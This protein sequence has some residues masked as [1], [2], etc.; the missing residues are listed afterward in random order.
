MFLN[1]S[2]TEKLSQN[3]SNLFKEQESSQNPYD[4]EIICKTNETNTIFKCHKTILYAR[5]YVFENFLNENPNEKRIILEDVSKE[6]IET[7]L[8]YL[9]T[10]KMQINLENLV[11]LSVFSSNYG[12]PDLT[13]I[14]TS[15]LQ[16]NC[17]IENVVELL[18]L[19]ELSQL[20]NFA[21]I[22]YEFLSVNFLTFIESPFVQELNENQWERILS[23][24]KLIADEFQIFQSLIKWAK[25]KSNILNPTEKLTEKEKEK[26][27]DTLINIVSEIR[28][29][30]F[31]QNQLDYV[32]QAS[33]VPY[34]LEKTLSDFRSWSSFII[35]DRYFD[36]ID[37]YEKQFIQQNQKNSIFRSRIN[38]VLFDSLI[39]EKHSHMRLIKSWISDHKFFH[40]M[41]LGFSTRKDG[42]SCQKW[43]DLCDNQ[44]K[45]LILI[46]TSDNFIFGGFTSVGWIQMHLFFLLQNPRNDPP[47][48]F[49]VREKSYALEYDYS[50]SGPDFVDFGLSQDMHQGH[51]ESFGASYVIPKEIDFDMEKS[52]DYL[53]GSFGEWEVQELETYFI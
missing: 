12:F 34:S 33:L 43:H 49:L 36:F 27:H 13:E 16:E 53:G 14:A 50:E 9:Y 28:F 46:K 45:T 17:Q 52:W 40:S 29:I 21:S 24:D 41:K 31:Q 4:F 19:C 37:G 18:K 7:V 23:N 6:T 48:R 2:N 39:L 35:H 51:S 47:Q 8:S 15:F 20:S 42:F 3:L 38:S 30:E 10:G 44:G 11:Q 1:Y 5:L 22:C 26:I 25:F 32:L